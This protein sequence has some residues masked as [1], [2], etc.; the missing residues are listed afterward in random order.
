MNKRF[1]STLF[2]GA[3]FLATMSMFVSCK[4]YDEDISK[5]QAQIDKAAL[6]SDLDALST[7]LSTVAANAQAAQTKAEE[8]LTAAQKAQATADAAATKEALEAVKAIA[9]KAGQDAAKAIEDA[10]KAQATADDAATAAQEGKD[11]AAA[12]QATADQAVADAAAAAAAANKV[13]T[14][15][16]AAL[17]RIG[18]LEQTYVTADALNAQIEELKATLI[19]GGDGSSPGL[20]EELEKEV[21]A[22]SGAI[23]ELYSA[24]TS[25]ELIDSFT[26]YYQSNYGYWAYEETQGNGLNGSVGSYGHWVDEFDD[27][28]NVIGGSWIT[29][30]YYGYKRTININMTHGSV[31][32]DSKFGDNELGF[33]NQIATP[34]V[35][36][37][38]DADVK[39]PQYGLIVRVNPVNADITASDIKLLNSKGEVLE[40]VKVGTPER[41]NR[42][43]TRG[44]TVNSGLWVLPLEIAEGISAK[45]FEQ[46]ANVIWQDEDATDD[47]Y[48]VGQ[49]ILFAVG[50]NNTAETDASRYVVSSY[51]V[52]VSYRAY[53]PANHFTFNVQKGTVNTSVEEIHNRWYNDEIFGEGMGYHSAQNPELIWKEGKNPIAGPANDKI[54]STNANVEKVGAT[55]RWSGFNDMRLN[56]Q[57]FVVAINE[58]FTVNAL[59]AYTEWG[60]Q[61]AIDSMYVVVDFEN[62]VESAPSEYN[63]W[64]SY[65]IEGVNKTVGADK[66]IDLKVVTP[67]ADGDV[68]GF[69]VYAVNRDGS[70]VDPDGR[71]FYILVT[72]AA[73]ANNVALNVEAT[74][75]GSTDKSD[76]KDLAKL[77]NNFTYELSVNKNNPHIVT[78]TATSD[79]ID[80]T[81]DYF[82]FDFLNGGSVVT[83]FNGTGE[84]ATVTG[85]NNT[86]KQIQITPKNIENLIDGATYSFT[87]TGYETVGVGAAI[88]MVPRQVITITLTK[89]MPAKAKTVEFRPKQEG[90]WNGDAWTTKDGS[91]KFMAY[92]IPYTT[93]WGEDYTATVAKTNGF[94]N[95]NNVFYNLNDEDTFQFDFAG[96]TK[97]TVTYD[98][99][100]TDPNFY[101]LNVKASEIDGKTEH[102]VTTS[103]VY[104]GI[105][106]TVEYNTDGTVKKVTAF[107]KDYA[108]A[109]SQSLTAIYA[110]W[111]H[112]ITNKAWTP[113]SSKP[114]LQWKHEGNTVTS[115]LANIKLTNSYDNVFFGRTLSA[116]MADDYLVLSTDEGDEAR[117]ETLDGRQV[118]PYF[119]VTV[120]T[121]GAI[122]FTQAS[123]QSD[124]NPVADHDENLVLTFKDAFGHKVEI[125]NAVTIRRAQ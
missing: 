123:I 23:E 24:V 19:G 5:L 33:D 66:S 58:T 106:T 122:T 101:I 50:I 115:S 48:H 63:A 60:E 84:K 121:D 41:F 112:A 87:L 80:A 62:S 64:K 107:S 65:T 11:A 75:A 39:D 82:T 72:G 78:G 102:A 68:I 29:D 18:K 88:T 25:V 27:E 15:L 40:A 117:L 85:L 79:V 56:K 38:K 94:K 73:G 103:S 91:N 95:L 52:A 26:G 114:I 22:Y 12:A 97:H 31:R 57:L 90:D 109:N 70:L 2:T 20:L 110:C 124:A 51:D 36:Y 9:E 67:T 1:L 46:V 93:P 96:G 16:S 89:N 71:A 6:K 10:A 32:E 61:I 105:S 74:T 108:V 49:Q 113:A 118:N 104:R 55:E 7:Q 125:S 111:H 77:D 17:E 47:S 81:L 92:M 69:R 119:K 120:A 34:L 76:K 3:F 54:A 28:G 37:K 8:A 44:S 4:D 45:D 43:I 100:G 98:L 59:K 86:V 53:E 35:E 116:L 99:A 14:D 30:G 83:T 21:K 42:L 13:N